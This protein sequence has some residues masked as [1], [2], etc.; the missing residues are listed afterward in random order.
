[1]VAHF[2][3]TLLLFH[4]T[5]NIACGRNGWSYIPRSKF[6]PTGFNYGLKLY[7]PILLKGRKMSQDLKT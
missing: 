5:E 7:W 2:D 3:Y 6:L 1:M 4:A